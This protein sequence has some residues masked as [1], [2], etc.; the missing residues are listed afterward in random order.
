[1]LTDK[2]FK[3]FE[4]FAKKPFAEH[5]RKGIKKE[6]KEKS[7]NALTL[8]INLLKKE[9]VINEKKIGKSGI[10]TL[11]L[12][13]D[14]TFYYLALCNNKKINQGMKISIKRIQ[15]ELSDFN[16]FYS[17]VIFGSYALNEQKKDSDLD[18][19][20]FIDEEEKIK[21]FIALINNAKL[22]SLIKLDVHVI[23]KNEMIEMLTNNEENLGKQIAKKH[24]AVYNH[25]IFYEIIKEGIKHGFRV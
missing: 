20:I 21:Q 22:K 18:I 17:I 16:P 25:K 23:A 9:E 13:N 10:L 19:A 24:L 4:I 12:N 8:A 15:D 2:Q 6:S 1:M 11:N 3:I 14:L 5:E 7:N